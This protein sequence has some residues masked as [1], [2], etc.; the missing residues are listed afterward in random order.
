MTFNIELKLVIMSA[1]LQVKKFQEFFSQKELGFKA[2]SVLVSGRF[3]PI[4]IFSFEEPCGN[5]VEAA[6]ET[7]F[8][9]HF[10]EKEGDILVFLTG[11]EEILDLK[12]SLQK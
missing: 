10:E 3:F 5:Y 6:L 2:D 8:Q 7:I 12:E 11:Q 4:E 9:I 1:T